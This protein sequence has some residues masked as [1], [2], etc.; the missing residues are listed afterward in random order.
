MFS[1]L[2]EIFSNPPKTEFVLKPVQALKNR[3]RQLEVEKRRENMSVTIALPLT[4]YLDF[5]R[6]VR[7][8]LDQSDVI[9]GLQNSVQNLVN[10]VHTL[11]QER[12]RELE[13]R[14]N[15]YI[16]VVFLAICVF[17]M[18]S[19]IL[20]LYYEMRLNF[21]KDEAHVRDGYRFDHF[22]EDRIIGVERKFNKL[23]D[24]LKF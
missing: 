14:K 5:S 3:V 24:K 4:P 11:N 15:L 2:G 9:L 21:E 22:L 23:L 1:S 20:F 19:L 12:F 16:L 10:D 6:D 17:S 7:S 18:M 13:L 8:V